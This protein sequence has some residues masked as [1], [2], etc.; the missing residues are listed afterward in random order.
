[1]KTNYL[2]MLATLTTALA[3]STAALVGSA[4]AA[5]F[6]PQP[7]PP[8]KTQNDDAAKRNQNGYAVATPAEKCGHN[9]LLT[10]W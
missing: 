6:N 7:D 9:H 10:R 5:D 3:L 2:Q 4:I 8:G 1:M